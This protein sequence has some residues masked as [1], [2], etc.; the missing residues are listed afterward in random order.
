MLAQSC[1]RG[2]CAAK[3]TN[4]C[5]TS[6]SRTKTTVSLQFPSYWQASS[7]SFDPRLSSKW[8]AN[9]GFAQ[10]ILSIPIP[11]FTLQYSDTPTYPPQPPA[12]ATIADNILPPQLSRTVF[13]KCLQHVSPLIR[14]MSTGLLALALQ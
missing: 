1:S 13:A 7:L 9:V 5:C 6:T 10:R 4:G 2:K 8:L 3:V 14:H 12:I 11:S